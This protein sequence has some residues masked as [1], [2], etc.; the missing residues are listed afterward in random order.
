MIESVRRLQGVRVVSFDPKL[1]PLNAAAA[2][3]PYSLENETNH[4]ASFWLNLVGSAQNRLFLAGI[5]FVGWR[6]I[7]GMKEALAAVG[8]SG[9]DVRILTVDA[10]N[11]M[12]E[13]MMNPDVTTLDFSSQASRMKETRG[14]FQ[15]SLGPALNGEVRSIK[16]G[17][18]LQQI[19]IKDSEAIISPYLYSANTGF[20]PCIKIREGGPGFA[21][22]VGEFEQLWKVNAHEEHQDGKAKVL[23]PQRKK[24]RSSRSAG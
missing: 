5:S 19:I 13:S 24:P 14:W 3:L 18:L 11:P 4:S 2:D 1:R 17:T 6:G 9:C 15:N 16:R 21:A 22:Y 10:E 7:P 12:F 8:A 23:A 20:S